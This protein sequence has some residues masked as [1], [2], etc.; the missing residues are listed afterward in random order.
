MSHFTVMVRLDKS[1]PES[2]I[3]KELQKALIPYKEHDCGDGDEEGLEPYLAF[4]DIEDESRKDWQSKTVTRVKMPDG[5]LLAPYDDE[6]K[7]KHENPADMLFSPRHKVPDHLEM[8]EVPL[9]DIYA[10]FEKYMDEYVHSRDPKTGKY[11]HW[12]NPNRKWDWYSIG[13]R[14]SGRIPTKGEPVDFCRIRDIDLRAADK[15][16]TERADK[17]WAEWHDFANGMEFPPFEGPREMALSIGLLDCKDASELTGREWKKIKWKERKD[18]KEPRYD[19]LVSVTAEEFDREYKFAFDTL[20]P[21]ACLDPKRTPP[22][23][24]IAPGEM[25]WFGFSSASAKSYLDYKRGFRDW[26]AG[27]DQEDL[28]VYVDCHI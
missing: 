9:K 14:Y 22:A 24:W 7:V 1:I 3:E 20:A 13:G 11:G 25:G 21:Y 17:F 6:F 2:D 26:L 18:L 16:L 28:V 5:R 23:G 15:Q 12:Q 8:V 19:V 4:N 27:G 10:T